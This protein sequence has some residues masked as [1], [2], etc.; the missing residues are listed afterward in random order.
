EFQALPGQPVKN[1][2]PVIGPAVTAQ[3]AVTQVVRE[4]E[5]NIGPPGARPLSQRGC[6]HRGRRCQGRLEKRSTRDG[7]A[8]GR[9]LSSPRATITPFNGAEQ[10]AEDWRR[11]ARRGAG[12]RRRPVAGARAP[13]PEPRVPTSCRVLWGLPQRPPEGGRLQPS[14]TRHG[15]YRPERGFLGEGRRKA[16]TARHAAARLPKAGRG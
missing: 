13:G 15:S 4:D 10:L 8:H 11:G 16:Q 1:W 14:R 7:S 3:V 6:R 5:K 9:I 2:C 12:D